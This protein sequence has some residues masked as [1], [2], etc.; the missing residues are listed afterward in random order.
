ML[1][2]LLAALITKFVAM[3][4]KTVSFSAVWAVLGNTMKRRLEICK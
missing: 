3:A 2:S 1:C 4:Y